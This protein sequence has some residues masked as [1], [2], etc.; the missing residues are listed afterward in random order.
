MRGGDENKE[1][2]V[3]LEQCLQDTEWINLVCFSISKYH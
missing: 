1:S 3:I 2:H